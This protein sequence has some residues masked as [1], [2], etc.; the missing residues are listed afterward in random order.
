MSGKIGIIGGSGF[1]NISGI[2][3]VKKV[4][5]STPFGK[6]SDDFITGTLEGKEVVF[7]ARHG[8][9]HKIL[10]GEINY[11]ANI[12]GM[13]KLGVEKIIS[14]SAC[15]SLKEEHKPL[16]IVIPDQF[17]DRTNIGRLMT[18]FGNG[19]VAHIPFAEP[20]CPHLAG[21]LA[22][23]GRKVG[24]N[25]QEGGVYVNM[26]GPQFSTKAESK[27]YRSWGVDIIGMTNLAEA[28]LAREAE[29]CYA[30]L[31]CITDYDCWRMDEACESV[32]LEMVMQN[33]RKNVDVSKNILKAVLPSLGVEGACGCSSALK[34]SIV[35]RPESIAPA[36]KKRLKLIIGKYIK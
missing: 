24:A 17:I 9:G 7:L 25:I 26:E 13:K 29:I 31:A 14:V 36:V 15:G 10:P 21:A 5:V 12:Y 22:D 4:K 23:A 18:F 34:D 8:Q 16:D 33:L 6:P 28:K 32:T 19:I 27:L 20:V 2:K 1:Y 11:R 30:T 35:T 3:N